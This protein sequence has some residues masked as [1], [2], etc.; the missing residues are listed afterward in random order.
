MSEPDTRRVLTEVA[1]AAAVKLDVLVGRP[2]QIDPLTVAR[3]AAAL[4]LREQG[5]PISAIARALH[6]AKPWVFYALASARESP[7]A[8]ELAEQVRARLGRKTPTPD[9]IAA[10]LRAN[11]ER[12]QAG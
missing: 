12:G 8:L 11:R 9:E 1:R 2:N 4:L 5:L 7:E 6:R 3:L 10:I